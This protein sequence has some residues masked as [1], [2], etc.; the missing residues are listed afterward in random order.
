MKLRLIVSDCAASCLPKGTSLLV[1]VLVS[2][3]PIMVVNRLC[4][5]GQIILSF[6]KNGEIKLRIE[7]NAMI[8]F[9]ACCWTLFLYG[10]HSN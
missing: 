3:V 4:C 2:A 6:L 5:T 8:N 9:I 10:C 7:V 1:D